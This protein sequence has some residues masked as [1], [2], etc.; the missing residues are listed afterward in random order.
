LERVVR[1][2]LIVKILFTQLLLV[3]SVS[4]G[5]ATP[6]VVPPLTDEAV[7]RFKSDPKAI[8]A[9]GSDTRAIE[10]VVTD[11]AAT[12]ASLA[13][14]L[15]RL[16]E[17]ATPAF[18]MAIAAG[19]AKAA[20]ACSTI[21]QHA[22]LLIQQAVAGFNDGE[23]QNAFAAVAGDLSTAATNAAFSSAT[24]SVGSVVITN[25]NASPRAPRNPG[26]GG[27]TAIFQIGSGGIAFAPTIGRA[28]SSSTAANPVSA[29]R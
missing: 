21:D 3:F 16:A 28:T 18:R 13:A 1:T 12:D 22:A 24:G 15:V 27:A 20:M 2:G 11:L 29:T 25:P 23:F 9:P 10:G 19:L 8:I 5:M 17:G 4:Q 6:C 26:G 7:S 14:D